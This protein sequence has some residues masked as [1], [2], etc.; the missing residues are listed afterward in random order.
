MTIDMIIVGM[1]K[2]L[3]YVNVNLSFARD[4]LEL[5]IVKLD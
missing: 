1:S 2:K 4:A 5:K 3:V